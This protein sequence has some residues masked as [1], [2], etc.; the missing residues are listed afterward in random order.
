MVPPLQ[1][2]GPMCSDVRLKVH[3]RE[4]QS[5][6]LALD[7]VTSLHRKWTRWVPVAVASRGCGEQWRHGAAASSRSYSNV[8]GAAST[9]ALRPP[10]PWPPYERRARALD[11]PV[12]PNAL[13]ALV[14]L[15][16]DL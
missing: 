6:L 1:T 8:E 14:V 10:P 5:D 4:T 15:A 13:R 16:R 11:A 2:T 9:A 7:V 3:L 12:V